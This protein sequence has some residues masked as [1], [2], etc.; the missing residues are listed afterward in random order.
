MCFDFYPYLRFVRIVNILDHGVIDNTTDFGSVVMGLS[1]VG[2]T[3]VVI[4]FSDYFLKLFIVL[5]FVRIV[6]LFRARMYQ[7][8]RGSLARSLWRV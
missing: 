8:W 4:V 1:P 6:K 3:F 5:P 7:D 2:P